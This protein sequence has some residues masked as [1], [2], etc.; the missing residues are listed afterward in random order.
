MTAAYRCAESRRAVVL[1]LKG[2]GPTPA[3]VLLGRTDS[4]SG[5]PS[6]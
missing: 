6:V 4:R 5:D 3:W 2:K 1:T